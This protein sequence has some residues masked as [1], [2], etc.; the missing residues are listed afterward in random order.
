MFVVGVAGETE[1][2]SN[3]AS[4]LSIKLVETTRR[5][6][7]DRKT[8]STQ[9][10]YLR[11]VLGGVESFLTRGLPGFTRVGSGL[12][13]SVLNAAQGCILTTLHF[14]GYFQ[15]GPISQSDTLQ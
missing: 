12:K 5:M 9:V 1:R 6:V 15:T 3:S 11:S 13:R 14:L 8:T 4:P 10:Y 2:E 7:K